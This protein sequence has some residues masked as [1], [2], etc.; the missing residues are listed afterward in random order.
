MKSS[1]GK[2]SATGLSQSAG[3]SSTETL[4]FLDTEFSTL[5]GEARLISLAL[6][7][8][9]GPEFYVELTDNWRRDHCSNFVRRV[10]LP[11]LDL[12]RHGCT[13]R[14]ATRRLREFLQTLGPRVEIATD[15]PQWDWDFFCQLA[16]DQTCEWP[17]NVSRVPRNSYHL[18]AE[19]DAEPP[20]GED[21]PHHALLDA[22]LCADLYR[23]C[24]GI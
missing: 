2:S 3:L 22:R 16:Y 9:G 1:E 20:S 8:P 23:R 19:W 14:E 21:V 24:R 13:T 6:V 4:A 11:Q 7:V 15:A 18:L 17:A 10:V 12:E 5:S